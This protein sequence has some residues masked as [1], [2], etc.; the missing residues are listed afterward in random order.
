MEQI[1]PPSVPECE[2]CGSDLNEDGLCPNCQC[3]I[4]LVKWEPDS[5]FRC[6][7]CGRLV[8][9][10]CSITYASGDTFCIECE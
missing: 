8:C 4:C 2:W 5:L 3:E 6:I 7:A 9:P 10:D 1:N